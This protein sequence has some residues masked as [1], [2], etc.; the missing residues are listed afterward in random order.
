[1]KRRLPDWA[2]LAGAAVV[3]A[4]AFF[5]SAGITHWVIGLHQTDVVV[6]P[7]PTVY[8]TRPPGHRHPPGRALPAP[9]L[10]AHSG[11]VPS[12]QAAH[13]RPDHSGKHP[14]GSGAPHHHGGTGVGHDRGH[15][16]H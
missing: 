7:G 8:L 4:A 10:S 14:R 5:A 15:R 16:H 1:M 11:G 12:P 2:I 13:A 3:A 6:R 9:A